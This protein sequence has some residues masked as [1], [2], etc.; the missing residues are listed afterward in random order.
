MELDLEPY[1][2][3]FQNWIEEQELDLREK[4]IFKFHEWM[5]QTTDLGP[6]TIYDYRRYVAEILNQQ[7]EIQLDK[8]ELTSHQKAALSKFEVFISKKCD[9]E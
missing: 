5:R 8:Q 7:G 3:D 4:V 1:P 2:S 6:G 9:E